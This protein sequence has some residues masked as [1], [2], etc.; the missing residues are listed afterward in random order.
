LQTSGRLLP[1]PERRLCAPR[2][3]LQSRR[4]AR[5]SAP[6]ANRRT[7]STCGR[8]TACLCRE[9]CRC[10]SSARRLLAKA[11]RATAWARTATHRR[12]AGT[13]PR[14]RRRACRRRPRARSKPL[15]TPSRASSPRSCAAMRLCRASARGGLGAG[16]VALGLHL[17]GFAFAACVAM[18]L[19]VSVLAVLCAV[20]C[21]VSLEPEEDSLGV[22]CY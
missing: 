19:A 13:R 1:R 12:C 14:P 11:P 7:S 5:F 6:A 3:R 16:L 15:P 8:R 2:G 10:G 18:V 4:S 20:L 17:A 9:A 22:C 21:T